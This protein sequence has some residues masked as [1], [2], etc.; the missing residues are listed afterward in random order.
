MAKACSTPSTWARSDAMDEAFRVAAEWY[1]GTNAVRHSGNL[2]WDGSGRFSLVAP[3]SQMEFEAADLRFGETRPGKTVYRRKS[4]PDFRLILPDDIPPGLAAQLPA[5]SDYGAWVDRMGLGKAAGIFAVVSAAAV[6]LFMTA[7]DWL[8]PRI[9]TSW[10]RNI[11]E[12][13]VGDFGGRI[14]HTPAGD[15]ALAKL[16]AKV[17]PAEEKV[18][19]GVA[20]MDMVNAVALPGGQVLL[21]DGLVQ[22]AESPEEL[23]GVLG[24][25]VG[26]VRE[27]HVMTA[28]LRQFGLSILLAGA[29]SGVSNSVFGLASMGYSRD[30]EREADEY[31]RARMAQSE[32]SPLGAAGFFER[33]AKEHGDTEN[34]PALVGWLASH[35]SS[36]ERAKAYRD[37]VRKG[38][39]YPPVLTAQEFEALKSMCREDPDVEEF[40]FF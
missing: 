17:D 35:P 2:S 29:D 9:P 21:F 12:A 31:A 6:A 1:D 14:C 27:R 19:A 30:A 3:A 37:A 8:G 13:M 34:S 25:E 18:R 26:H 5:K 22:Q 11:G 40:D 15:A 28:L 38:A 7:P 36:G 10:E 23:A 33:M 16:L 39:N 24:H 4:V 32:I 20:N